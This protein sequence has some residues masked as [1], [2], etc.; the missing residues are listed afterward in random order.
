MAQ[1]VNY[2]IREL[3]LGEVKLKLP[4]VRCSRLYSEAL[5]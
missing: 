1:S 5:C 3:I 4:P 2:N